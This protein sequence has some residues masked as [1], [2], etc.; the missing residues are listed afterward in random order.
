MSNKIS[1][2]GDLL[3][4]AMGGKGK[5]DA[6]FDVISNN[7]LEER[8]QIC[9]YYQT[10]YNQNLYDVLKEKLS[11]NF[12]EL[13]IHLFLDPI[14]YKAKMLKKAMRG[15]SPDEVVIIETLTLHTQD[16]LRAIEEAYKEET[17]RDLSKDIEKNFSGTMRKNLLNLLY[18]PRNVNPNPDHNHCKELANTLAEA[19]ESHWA[20]DENIFRDVFITSSG[21]E[22]V[23]ISRYYLEKT[24]KN[25]IEVVENKLSGK[26]K[27]LLREVIYNNIIPCELFAEKIYLS[28]KGLGTNNNLLNRVLVSRSYVDMQEI[29]DSYRSKYGT[30]MRKDVAGDTSGIYQELCEYLCQI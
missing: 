9:D 25:L 16:E 10:R 29:R 4:G 3:H 8:L 11:G 30:T 22:L 20:D 6:V 15:F 23:L 21:E 28:C 24:G 26:N 1:E 19:G 2:A 12:K 13:A 7:N 5:E 14:D 27:T 18:T 17:N